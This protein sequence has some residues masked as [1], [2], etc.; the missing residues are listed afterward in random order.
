[1]KTLVL[2]LLTVLTTGILTGCEHEH[3]EHHGGY[4]R[5]VP[6]EYGHGGY[7]NWEHR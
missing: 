5:P 2:L 1:M 6:Y 3:W 7:Y 4:G